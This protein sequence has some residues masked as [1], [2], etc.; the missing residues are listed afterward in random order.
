MHLY[1]SFVCAVPGPPQ[2]LQV[3]VLNST[4]FSVTWNEPL[5]RNGVV[6]G[7]RLNYSLLAVDDYL[8][9][10]YTEV[11]L[12]P[13]SRSYVVS[14]LHPYAS[15]QLELRAETDKGLGGADIQVAMTLESG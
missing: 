13:S 6:E 10:T 8:S 2:I 14:G 12:D 7:Y 15:Y 5:E 11:D 1:F 9:E 4:S 3:D